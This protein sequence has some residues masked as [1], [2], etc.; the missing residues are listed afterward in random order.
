VTAAALLLATH[1]TIL[2]QAE[3][4]EAC[5]QLH[6]KSKAVLL[7]CLR[8]WQLKQHSHGRRIFLL[9]FLIIVVSIISPLP[10]CM[11]ARWRRLQLYAQADQLA[12]RYW[13]QQSSCWRSCKYWQREGDMV[14]D[15]GFFKQV[16]Y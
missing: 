13:T 14:P 9:L 7:Y 16:L 8:A 10:V 15:D 11:L 12:D 1:P 2:Q 5:C 6:Q 4:L 3:T